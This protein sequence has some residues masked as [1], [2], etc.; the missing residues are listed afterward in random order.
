MHSEMFNNLTLSGNQLADHLRNRFMGNIPNWVDI[1]LELDSY[2]HRSLDEAQ[3]KKEYSSLRVELINYLNSIDY[4]K[5]IKDS[6][7]YNLLKDNIKP[8]DDFTIFDFNYTPTTKSILLELGISVKAFNLVKIHGDLDNKNIIF[9]IHDDAGDSELK[10]K[11]KK[12]FQENFEGARIIDIMNQSDHLFIFGHSLGKTD[13]MYFGPPFRLYTR[14][15]KERDLSLYYYDDNG[16]DKLNTRINNL[17]GG[18][19]FGFRKHTKVKRIK[20]K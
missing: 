8:G 4:K 9:G 18:N 12:S 5:Y 10:V 6:S 15:S 3:F 20:T 19:G 13:E 1:E 16:L 11:I 7:A 17:I 2:T 14:G